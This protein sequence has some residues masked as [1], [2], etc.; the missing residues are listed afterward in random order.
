MKLQSNS[1]E[2]PSTRIKWYDDEIIERIIDER[3]K[4]FGL[5]PE[6]VRPEKSFN[7]MTVQELREYV[8]FISRIGYW[9]ALYKLLDYH[10]VGRI[11]KDLNDEFDRRCGEDFVELYNFL[12]KKHNTEKWCG[13]ERYKLLCLTNDKGY[14]EM[15]CAKG[16]IVLK[17]IRS[18][19]ST[20]NFLDLIEALTN[21][22]KNL[23]YWGFDKEDLYGSKY[24]VDDPKDHKPLN[25]M[26]KAEIDAQDAF[27]NSL[28][29][30]K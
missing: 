30:N 23:P 27:I 20:Y 28:L 24:N 26:R 25:D 13:E 2:C 29:I 21:A 5:T 3:T 17:Q 16:V 14:T 19:L 7:E 18:E 22:T 1:V 8:T 11:K 6:C 12:D 15:Q 9:N 10:E 4:K